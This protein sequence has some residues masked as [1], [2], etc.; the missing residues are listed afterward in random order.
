MFGFVVGGAVPGFWGGLSFLLFN[1]PEGLFSR[2]FWVAVYATCPFWYISG[3]KAI[4]LMPLFNGFL[5]A[6]IAVF[7]NKVTEAVRLKKF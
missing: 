7:I 5:Y 3:E 4:V 2:A 1:A 6:T